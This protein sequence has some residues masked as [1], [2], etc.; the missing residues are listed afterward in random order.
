LRRKWPASV[1]VFIEELVPVAYLN[2]S[3]FLSEKGDVFKPTDIDKRL[4]L[5]G[6]NGPQGQQ[7]HVWQF[8]NVLYREIALLNYEVVRLTLDERRAWQL[9]IIEQI[10]T[11]DNPINVRLGIFDTEKRLQRFVRI[12]PALNKEYACLL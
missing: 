10:E 9:V 1:T 11:G 8:M 5:P 6:L 7:H 3:A 4:N 2:K 12:L